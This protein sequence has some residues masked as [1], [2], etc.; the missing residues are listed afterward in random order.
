M[1]K[2][3]CWA[4]KQPADVEVKECPHCGAIEPATK[5]NTLQALL[6]LAAILAFGGLVFFG[7]YSLPR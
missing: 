5:P 3:N 4:C 7:V 1:A 6:T 2:I